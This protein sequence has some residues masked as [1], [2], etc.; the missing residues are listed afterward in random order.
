MSDNKQLIDTLMQA[1]AQALADTHTIAVAKV[2]GVGA[3]TISCRPVI[4]R[5]VNGQSV[6][7]P[8]F[9]EVPPVFLQGGGSYTAHP[10]AVDDYC[11]LL[12]SERCFDQWYAGADFASPLELR[13]H[14]Y[15][16]GFALVGI[17]PQAS[18]IIIPTVIQHTGDANQDGNYTHQGIREQTGDHIQTGDR[19]LTG[20][21]DHTGAYNLSGT[22]TADDFKSDGQT[23]VS[24]SFTTADAKT[25]TV[26][27]GI[28]T[29]II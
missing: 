7:L 25:V 29:A 1:A 2:T 10:I 24:G 16:D 21:V 5:E 6:E 26:T 4:N 8:E 28:I 15:S 19:T 17:N 9:V 22:L 14:D 11:L 20:D 3:T 12:F 18:A 13:M 27:N 23:G